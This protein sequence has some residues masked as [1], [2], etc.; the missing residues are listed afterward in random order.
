MNPLTLP[1]L[2]F[3]GLY[4]TIVATSFV[5]AAYVRWYTRLPA[6]GA[7]SDD[8]ELSP[9]E[10]AYLGG[11]EERAL[12]ATI[13]RLV[14]ARV[15]DYDRDKRVLTRVSDTPPPDASHIENAFHTVAQRVMGESDAEAVAEELACVLHPVRTRLEDLRLLVAPR[16]KWLAHWGPIGLASIAVAVGATR[17]VIHYWHAWNAPPGASAAE[18]DAFEVIGQVSAIVLTLGTTFFS[19]RVLRS[20]RGDAVLSRL[21]KKHAHL[22]FR[23]GRRLAELSDEELLLAIGLFGHSVVL[24]GPLGALEAIFEGAERATSGH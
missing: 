6:A 7:P 8:P 18:L 3:L 16:E 5:L 24:G 9:Y 15:F 22:E 12:Q 2:P 14:R 20:R 23:A 10:I 19:R 1:P 4:G 11:G 13:A 21:Q 17:A